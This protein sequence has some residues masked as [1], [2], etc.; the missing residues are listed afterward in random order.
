VSEQHRANNAND[1]Q[2]NEEEP[3]PEER[4]VQTQHV[5]VIDD[6]EIPYTATTGTYVLKDKE[7]KA[8]AEIFFVAYTRDDVDDRTARPITFAFNGGPGSSSVWL[9]LGMLGP[10]KVQMEEFGRV[11]PPHHLERNPHSLLDITDLVFIDPVSTGFSKPAPGEKAE[12]F[13]GYEKDIETVGEFIRLYVTRNERWLS[14]KFLIGESY[15]TTRGSGLIAHMMD[16]HGMAFNGL[17]LI[18][19]VL[20]FQ[21]ISFTTGNDLPYLLYL[22]TYAATAWYHGRLPEELQSLPLETLLARVETFVQEAYLPA[23]FRGDALPHS[24]RLAIVEKLAQFTGLSPDYILQTNLRIEIFRFTKALLRDQRRTVGRLDSRYKGL[25][26]DAA[27]ERFEYDPTFPQLAALYTAAFNDYVRRELGF[28]MDEKYHVLARLYPNWDFGAKNKFLDVSDD[29]RK[30]IS[31]NPQLQVFIAN[32]YYDL[33]T[34]YFATRYTIDHLG[35]EPEL[36]ENIHAS[37]YEAGH[38]MYI[39]PS[40][41]A[42]LR[43]RL[44]TFIT[45]S[46]TPAA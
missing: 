1:K 31:Q 35:L 11:A 12:D 14:P 19:V 15:G 39:H 2:E 10:R 4:Q 34:P 20:N 40:S 30:T 44:L 46:A 24:E 7:G 25:D 38:M 5:T 36:R 22:P 41:L 23:L 9:H 28:A 3:A 33:A 8:K 27:G 45:E 6:Q 42:K 29:L 32:G 21:T 26:R 13:H 18:S 17:M 43:A 16:T 37:W